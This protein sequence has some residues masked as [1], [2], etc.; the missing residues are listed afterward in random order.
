MNEL[1]TSEGRLTLIMQVLG[2]AAA[3]L[4]H[5]SSTNPY[6]QVAALV[7]GGAMSVLSTLGYQQSRTA[8]KTTP[9]P[10]LDVATMLAQVLDAALKKTDPMG[11][12]VPAPV[13]TPVV[14]QPQL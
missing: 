6:V 7:V 11:A 13:V 8:V 14:R 1:K 3:V 9:A 12:T 10:Q 4:G 5:M 2:I